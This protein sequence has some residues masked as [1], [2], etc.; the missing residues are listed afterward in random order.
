LA[1]KA[2]EQDQEKCGRNDAKIEWILLFFILA[3]GQHKNRSGVAI[4]IALQLLLTGLL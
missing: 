3:M 1:D 4:L 2:E